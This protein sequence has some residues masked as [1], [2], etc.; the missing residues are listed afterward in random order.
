MN[1]SI[2]RFGNVIN[3]NGSVVPLFNKQIRNRGPVTVTHPEVTRYLMTIPDAVKLILETSIIS[4]KYKSGLIY[5]L[6][7]GKP[8][9]IV[10]LAKK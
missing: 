6:D 10:D 7:M 3:S 2:V 5:M 1:I 4:K 9:R 8:I